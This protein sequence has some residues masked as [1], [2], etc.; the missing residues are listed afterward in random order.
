MIFG[1][2]CPLIGVC[3]IVIKLIT[4]GATV[5]MDSF[6]T[7][8]GMMLFSVSLSYTTGSSTFMPMVGAVSYIICAVYV[9]SEISVSLSAD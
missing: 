9:D 1:V 3:V 2:I 7:V 4:V 8:C 5:N 6:N